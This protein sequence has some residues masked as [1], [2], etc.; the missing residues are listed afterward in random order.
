MKILASE[1]QADVKI[2]LL[3][4][5]KL[6]TNLSKT[7]KEALKIHNFEGEGCCFLSESKTCFV[8]LEKYNYEFPNALS[9]ALANAIQS[10]KKLKIKSVSIEIDKKEEIK[11]A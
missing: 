6:P 9:D 2:I 11:K 1:K 5:K 7:E 10:L 8:G 4:D 3:R